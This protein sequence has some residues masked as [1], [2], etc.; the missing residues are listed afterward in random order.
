MFVPGISGS[1]QLVGHQGWID[2]T[3]FA[4]SAVAPSTSGGTQPCQIAVQKLVDMASPHLW[5]ATVN[6]QTFTSPVK[7]Q[8]L[9]TGVTTPFVLYD[10]QLTNAQITSIGD[11]GS[12]AL[13][14]ESLTLKASS[15]TLTFNTQNT[16]GTITPTTT[17]FTC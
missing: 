9:K 14:G 3:S 11:S 12:S 1:S 17:S 5:V 4:G 2:V 13:P 15:V 7:I 8:V 6:A 16:N 10:I